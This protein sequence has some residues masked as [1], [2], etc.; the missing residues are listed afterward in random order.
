MKLHNAAAWIVVSLNASATFAEPPASLPTALA[1]GIARI[2]PQNIA[3]HVKLLASDEFEGR[4]PGTRGETLTIRYLA[5]KLRESG[6][7][8][9]NPDGTYFQKV[10]LVGYK[11]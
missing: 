5:A 1:D 11:T 9:G 6:L 8:P 4:A 10:P 2:Q 3:A 7:A